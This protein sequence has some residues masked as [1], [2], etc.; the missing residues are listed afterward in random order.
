MEEETDKI[1]IYITKEIFC[2]EGVNK[3][4]TVQTELYKITF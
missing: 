3:M 4:Q 1:K 2:G